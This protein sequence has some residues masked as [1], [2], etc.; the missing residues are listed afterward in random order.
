[1]TYCECCKRHFPYKKRYIRK[2]ENLECCPYCLTEIPLYR[3]PIKT[4]KRKENSLDKSLAK[5]LTSSE[6]YDLHKSITTIL[7]DVDSK[8]W[9]ICFWILLIIVFIIWFIICNYLGWVKW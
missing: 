8:K 1:M 9:K 5:G 4:M 6:I 3:K 7:C 2:E